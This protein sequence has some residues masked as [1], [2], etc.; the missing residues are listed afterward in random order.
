MDNP[1]DLD[2]TLNSSAD[3]VIEGSSMEIEIAYLKRLCEEKDKLI[4]EKDLVISIQGEFIQ[5]LKEQL[6]P[7]KYLHIRHS[8]LVVVL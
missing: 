4:K 5:S 2:Q 6:Y 7:L 8:H 3:T 1:V